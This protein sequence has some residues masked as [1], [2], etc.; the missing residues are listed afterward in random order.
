MLS[1][2]MAAHQIGVTRP[3]TIFGIRPVEIPR[4]ALG[5][6]PDNTGSPGEQHP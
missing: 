4:P 2:E 5:S 1:A 6:I 3:L